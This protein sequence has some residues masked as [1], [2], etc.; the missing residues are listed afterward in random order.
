MNILSLL[1][2]PSVI[3][4]PFFC[5]IQNAWRF[6][7]TKGCQAS[8]WQKMSY[9][10]LVQSVQGLTCFTVLHVLKFKYTH[11]VHEWGK[12]NVNDYYYFFIVR[13]NF[14]YLRRLQIYCTTW[15]DN[16][17]VLF[18]VLNPPSSFTFIVWN[19]AT[20]T[21]PLVFHW[22][23]SYETEIK[24]RWEDDSRVRISLSSVKQ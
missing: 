18:C 10:Y 7:L 21:S 8:K 5:R 19:R 1:T 12:D 24:R 4:A 2:H 23:K 9:K 15:I 14:C 16:F 6:L 22:R 13:R 11:I 17:F 20:W 3:P